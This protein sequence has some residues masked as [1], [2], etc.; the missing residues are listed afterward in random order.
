MRTPVAIALLS[1]FLILAPLPSAAQSGSDGLSAE[2]AEELKRAMEMLKAQGM[3]PKQAQ[4]LEQML[5]GAARQENQNRQAE[6]D[7]A[8]SAFLAEHGPKGTAVVEVDG[9]RFELTI[10]RCETFA[11]PSVRD[12]WTL[13][14]RQGP[15]RREPTLHVTSKGSHYQRGPI[16]FTDGERRWRSVEEFDAPFAGGKLRWSG[17]VHVQ[18]DDAAPAT[19]QTQLRVEADCRQTTQSPMP[20]V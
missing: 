3:D 8:R 18:A 13:S 9:E 10:T 19:G 7:R 6:A 17:A 1:V 4:Q 16:Q 2:Q 11:G 20:G 12:V 14:A 5:G 15:D